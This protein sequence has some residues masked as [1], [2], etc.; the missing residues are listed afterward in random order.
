MRGCSNPGRIT[1][2]S[3]SSKEASGSPAW[4]ID[5]AEDLISSLTGVLSARIVARPGGRIDEVHVLTTED[6]S[7]KQTVRNV[8]SAL[9]AHFE[10][11]VDHRKISVAQ[12]SRAIPL[13]SPTEGR[14][15]VLVEEA[16]PAMENRIL[17]RG[18]QMV[19]EDDH[20]VRVS[21]SLEWIGEIYEGSASAADLPRN[22]LEATAEATLRAIQN[23]AHGASEDDRVDDFRRIS[24][25]LDGVKILDAFEHQFVLVSVSA[26][27]GRDI[28]SL[29][30][31]TQIG[32]N[33]E[34]SVV[35]ATLQATDRW[36]RGRI[37]GSLS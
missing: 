8:E 16:E 24:L 1:D 35:L 29:T 22:R 12:T 13:T 18:Q 15:S 36:V 7:P 34:R 19:S 21:V 6:V 33:L 30:G 37:S 27:S 4:S 26:I 9:L 20:R 31:S 11:A 2:V 17:F 10:L 3:V 23:A 14:M 32:R 25:S 28:L 5:S